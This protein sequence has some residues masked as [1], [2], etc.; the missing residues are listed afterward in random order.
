MVASHPHEFKKSTIETKDL[1]ILTTMKL[2]HEKD[3]I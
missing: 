3:I 2:L 1:K